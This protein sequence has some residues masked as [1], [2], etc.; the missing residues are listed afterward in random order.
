[1]NARRKKLF[2]RRKTTPVSRGAVRGNRPARRS[3]CPLNASVEMIG[4][5]WSLLIL[6]DMMLRGARAFKELAATPEGIATNVLADRLASLAF[7]GIISARPDPH[8]RRR[9]VYELTAKGIDLAPVLAELVLWAS[10]HEQTG[11]QQLVRQLRQ[12]KHGMIAEVRRRWAEAR[13]ISARKTRP[14]RPP[15]PAAR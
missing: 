14:A 6:R 11:N 4:D 13:A 2:D 10:R 7:H 8:D 9:T 15:A 1:M 12:D 5:R 3:G